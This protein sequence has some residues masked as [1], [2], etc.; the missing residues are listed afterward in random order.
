LHDG[1]GDIDVDR[2]DATMMVRA[3][4]STRYDAIAL[5]ALGVFA[6]RTDA[7]LMSRITDLGNTEVTGITN[8]GVVL[9]EEQPLA[10]SSTP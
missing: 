10:S 4:I 5:L 3:R 6:L 9:G 2:R 8:A 1:G 7:A